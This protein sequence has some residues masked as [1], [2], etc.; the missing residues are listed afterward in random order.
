MNISRT[1]SSALRLVGLVMIVATAATAQD[2]NNNKAQNP[3]IGTWEINLRWTEAGSTN[4]QIVTVNN[5]LTGTIEDLSEGWKIELRDI[6][7]DGNALSFNYSFEKR[8]EHRADFTG[9]VLGNEINGTLTIASVNATMRGVRLSD[10]EAAKVAARPTILDMYEARTFAE[11]KENTLQYRLFIPKNYDP[12]E[13]YPLVLFH[14]GRGGI[15]D[16][17]ERQL[18]GAAA[19]EW[20][21]PESQAKYP[22]FIVAPQFSG[23][24]LESVDAMSASMKAYAHTVHEM[25]DS[26]EIEFSIDTDREYVTGLSFGGECTWTSLMERPDRFA[27]AVP[28]CATDHLSGLSIEERAEQFAKLPI[29][30]FHGD[31]DSKVPVERSQYMVKELTMEGGAPEYTEYPGVGHNSWDPAYRD[32]KLVAWLFAQNRTLNVELAIDRDIKIDGKYLN[33]PVKEDANKCVVSLAIEDEKVREFVV[34]LAPGEPDYWVYLEVQDFVGKKGTVNISGLNE[35][36]VEAFESV[37]SA[38]TFPGEEDLYKEELRPQF[39]FSSKRG[40]N[41]DPNGLVYYEGEYH[42]FYQ[43]N[44]FGW[45]WGNMTWG[46]AISTDL[47]HWVEQGDKLHMDELGQMWSGSG[48]VDWN[49]T[50]GFQTGDEPPLVL[51]YT[52]AGGENEW[53]KGKPFT[54]GLAYSN[55]RGRTWTKYSGN[56]VLGEV[57]KGTRDPKVQWWEETQ[58]WVIALYVDYPNIG[59]YTSKDLKK[60][61]PQGTMTSNH[62][63]PELV[64]LPVDGDKKNSKWVHYAAH[65]QYFIGEF[66]GKNFTKET[67][68]LRFNYGDMFYASQMFND[69]PEEDGRSIQVGWATVNLPEMPFNQMMTLPVSLDL[70]STDEGLRMFANPVHEIERLRG[71]KNT[72]SNESLKPG[73]N[74]LE[75]VQ[76]NLFDIEAKIKVGNADEVG[77]LING[78]PIV[79]SVEEQRLIGGEGKKDDEFSA[80]ETHVELAPEDG[81]ITLRIL[82]DRPSVEIFANEGR[83]YMPMQAVRDLNNK[84]LSIYSKGGTAHIDELTVYE[85]KS[86]WGT[87]AK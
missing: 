65:G 55:D 27:A 14:H 51:I 46:H 70:R 35:D 1:H 37:Y 66:D 31:A 62:E 67:E 9:T 16:D 30:I 53:S 74:P 10:E 48:V 2:E 82:V 73:D 11:S 8:D 60:W 75:K 61:E 6:T 21:L 32:P 18:E 76:G 28:I 41:N 83:V 84:S 77:L 85:M 13:K 54:Q 87:S 44:P 43:H 64:K 79:Y 58:E 59:F 29:W 69:I 63:C 72:W 17:N 23:E 52:N 36:Q 15:G 42:L 34:N 19:R 68:E 25:L 3:F 86:I 33:F 71:K 5:D 45:S 26:L 38:D 20:V 47:V 49:N 80:G 24:I 39:H 81:K 78:F 12:K 4:K 40:W 22:C 7:L 57:K 50:T 56:P